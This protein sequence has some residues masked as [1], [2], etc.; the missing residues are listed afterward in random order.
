MYFVIFLLLRYK[1]LNLTHDFKFALIY[2]AMHQKSFY[3]IKNC[4]ELNNW[5]MISS[6]F[7]E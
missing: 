6:I 1:I 4:P 7:E 2:L 3:V 5:K